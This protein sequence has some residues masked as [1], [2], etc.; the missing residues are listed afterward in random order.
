MLNLVVYK[1]TIRLENLTFPLL[2]SFV[3]YFSFYSFITYTSEKNPPDTKQTICLCLQLLSEPNA[4]LNIALLC[5]PSVFRRTVMSIK[6]SVTRPPFHSI[7]FS[8]PLVTA[9]RD[10]KCCGLLDCT[11]HMLHAIC[12]ICR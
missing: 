7:L 5:V 3:I 8:H 6:P 12:Y 11:P 10:R 4:C 9:L 2:I 1:V